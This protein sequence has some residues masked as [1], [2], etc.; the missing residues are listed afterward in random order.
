MS[1]FNNTC[2]GTPSGVVS[3]VSNSELVIHDL[4]LKGCTSGA[5]MAN[6][7][8]HRVS[9]YLEAGTSYT[10]IKKEFRDNF[11]LGEIGCDPTC[12]TCVGPT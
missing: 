3:V 10:E 1:F 7:K 5:L 6:L 4:D 8:M 11:V 12:Q 9:Y 2:T